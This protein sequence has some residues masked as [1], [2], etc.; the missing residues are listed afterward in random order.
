MVCEFVPPGARSG[1]VYVTVLAV[2]ETVVE[3]PP[4]EL[5]A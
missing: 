4:P 2:S 5:L 3:L 1:E